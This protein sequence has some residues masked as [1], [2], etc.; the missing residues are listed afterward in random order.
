[1]L[2][3]QRDATARAGVIGKRPLCPLPERGAHKCVKAQRLR[4]LEGAAACRGG[5]A[6]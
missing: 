4:T 6:E 1:M 2:A 5:G 3:R